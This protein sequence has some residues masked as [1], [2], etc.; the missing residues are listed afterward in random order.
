[1]QQATGGEELPD[2]SEVDQTE[3]VTN[4]SAIEHT[5][6]ERLLPAK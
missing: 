4:S 5:E 2:K 3:L 1:M 6:A